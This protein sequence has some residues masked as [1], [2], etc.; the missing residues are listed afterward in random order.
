MGIILYHESTVRG[1]TVTRSGDYSVVYR[2]VSDYTRI[3]NQCR[4]TLKHVERNE[5]YALM[6]MGCDLIQK[7]KRVVPKPSQALPFVGGLTYWSI[8][9]GAPLIKRLPK[10]LG[11]PFPSLE[12]H[13]F[14]LGTGPIE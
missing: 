3:F 10:I 12:N 7:W 13:F 5:P 4:L 1:E 6:Q 14:V 11:I 2:S 8:R 9:V